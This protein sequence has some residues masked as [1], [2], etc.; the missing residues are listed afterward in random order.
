MFDGVTSQ[1]K[2]LVMCSYGRRQHIY[3]IRD[4]TPLES[5]PINTL[6]IKDLL[7]IIT[8]HTKNIIQWNVISGKEQKRISN[9]C[10]D[11][12]EL[13][14]CVLGDR[15]RKFILGDS[16]GNVA[17]YSC[18]TVQKLRI[19]PTLPFSV[20]FLLYSDDQNV[21][22]V[23][24]QADIF[25]LDATAT[26]DDDSK[27]KL[28]EVKAHDVDIICIAYSRMFG[29]IATADCL[30]TLIIWDYLYLSMEMVINNV[31]SDS[32]I[33]HMIFLEPY[34]LLLI[35]DCYGN[36]TI[37]AVPPASQ[38]L[39]RRIWRV[40]TSVPK[41]PLNM[42]LPPTANGAEYATGGRTSR[43]QMPIRPRSPGS[44]HM[45][46]VDLNP[47]VESVIEEDENEEDAEAKAHA[48]S[49][50]KKC[51]YL[52]ERRNVKQL[53]LH[54]EPIPVESEE[55]GMSA[56][57]TIDTHTVADTMV[58]NGRFSN[59]SSPLASVSQ[60]QSIATSPKNR[61]MIVDNNTN[62]NESNNA[63]TVDTN[64]SSDAIA[65]ILMPKSSHYVPAA[66]HVDDA[67]SITS[68][69]CLEE[70][71]RGSLDMESNVSIGQQSN[72]SEGIPVSTTDVSNQ[73]SKQVLKEKKLRSLDTSLDTWGEQHKSP[74]VLSSP[75]TGGG[76]GGGFTS[77]GMLSGL[78]STDEMS[79]GPYSKR[80]GKKRFNFDEPGLNFDVDSENEEENTG[81]K[82]SEKK[83]V[84][85]RPFTRDKRVL[86]YCGM[87]DGTVAVTDITHA[88]VKINL[89]PIEEEEYVYNQPNYN[90]KKRL[91]RTVAKDSDVTRAT[92]TEADIKI[93]EKYC[94]STLELVWNAHK[95]S[96][97][98]MEFVGDF[99]DLMTSTE[100]G[101][102]LTWSE[103]G[104]ARGV[105]T[106]GREWDN[107][108]P[109]R[110][111]TPIDIE[112]RSRLRLQEAGDF[113]N[114]L[115]LTASLDNESYLSKQY[116]KHPHLAPKEKTSRRRGVINTADSAKGKSIG[117]HRTGTPMT[118]LS[119]RK[120]RDTYDLG[121]LTNAHSAIPRLGSSKN[122]TLGSM[123]LAERE[124]IL[125][126][127]AG[128]VTY[129][130]SKKDLANSVLS[131]KHAAAMKAIAKI[132]REES[133]ETKKKK[134]A[135]K[136]ARRKQMRMIRQRRDSTVGD[137]DLK[138]NL[139]YD[140]PVS[141]QQKAELAEYHSDK[142][143]YE[144]VTLDT[145]ALL[146]SVKNDVHIVTGSK[147]T[148]SK[149]DIELSQIDAEDSNNWE[150]QSTNRQRALYA[151]L[152][153]ELDRDG[154]LTNNGA[155][156]SLTHKLDTLSGGN[157]TAY[158][159]E[160][161]TIRKKQTLKNT[162]RLMSSSSASV[163]PSEMSSMSMTASNFDTTS[164]AVIATMPLL[165][166]SAEVEY[167][168]GDSNN[169]TS[170]KPTQT[171]SNS[172]KPGLML[173][174][175]QVES[176]DETVTKSNS[177]NFTSN[178]RSNAKAISQLRTPTTA[179]STKSM[180]K[181]VLSTAPSTKIGSKGIPAMETKPKEGAKVAKLH[182]LSKETLDSHMLKQAKH[183]LRNV[184]NSNKSIS[185]LPKSQDSIVADNILGK[186]SSSG[187][188]TPGKVEFEVSNN[189]GGVKLPPILNKNKSCPI[190]PN[191]GSDSCNMILK[192]PIGAGSR[193]NN[194]NGAS[195]PTTSEPE[196]KPESPSMG[197]GILDAASRDVGNRLVLDRKATPDKIKDTMKML[198]ARKATE[199]FGILNSK[200]NAVDDDSEFEM[201]I[202]ENVSDDN[203]MGSSHS[204]RQLTPPQTVARNLRS[205][206]SA[207][208]GVSRLSFFG[209]S[210]H[211]NSVSNT[212]DPNNP[213]VN[214]QQKSVAEI[215][216]NVAEEFASDWS[217]SPSNAGS[218]KRTDFQSFPRK[219]NGN[220]MVQDCSK[221]NGSEYLENKK[222]EQVV[223]K[224]E[225]ALSAEK[226]ENRLME[227]ESNY[228]KTVRARRRGK[229]VK[230][231]SVL[232]GGIISKNTLSNKLQNKKN[233]TN[234]QGDS[235][236]LRKGEEVLA[237]VNAAQHGDNT[238]TGSMSLG[239]INHSL[240][241]E[242]VKTLKSELDKEE[243][244]R[245]K[246][247]NDLQLKSID[248]F[249]AVGNWSRKAHFYMKGEKAMH[250]AFNREKHIGVS[251]RASTIDD[252]GSHAHKIDNGSKKKRCT[253]KEILART[254][255]GP[256]DLPDL[257]R[258]WKMFSSIH[259]VTMASD[260]S[261]KY[262]QTE[263]DDGKSF[264]MTT[265]K[266]V[267]LLVDLVRHPFI[268]LRPQFKMDI[269]EYVMSHQRSGGL[270]EQLHCTMTD[271]L[272]ALCP[273]MLPEDRMDCL[274]YLTL[275]ESE[276]MKQREI[277]DAKL[278]EDN[279]NVAVDNSLKISDEDFD[280]LRELFHYFDKDGSGYI[281]QEEVMQAMFAQDATYEA[282]MI[283]NMKGDSEE[284]LHTIDEGMDLDAAAVA[285][286]MQEGDH[287]DNAIL[288][289]KEF[290]LLFKD[291]LHV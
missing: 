154:L 79:E 125:L 185:K 260:G 252:G 102:V 52:K 131:A 95:A 110:W 24:G 15:K 177:T 134:M 249:S 128:E 267:I 189:E 56:H 159:N 216:A 227:I 97:C 231:R 26:E 117:S 268:K 44:Y 11:S 35:P 37:I 17:V 36:F 275:H 126:Q 175:S 266:D 141:E 264:V 167:I 105:L 70:M 119:T 219:D 40:V 10:N 246:V 63:L 74:G 278:A 30:G 206:L 245:Q 210:K 16:S 214:S 280:T 283:R 191:N 183:G 82:T 65:A 284:A 96:C 23:G 137:D 109:P 53:C 72:M 138:F 112:Q 193:Y 224:T 85:Y 114:K 80:N 136:Q 190:F 122:H 86:V 290:C 21:I 200:S 18:L 271:I 157:F 198:I 149:Y 90:S 129:D 155:P 5:A 199:K 257:L 237:I 182:C 123:P 55:N 146:A 31:V 282:K 139:N 172:K 207:A 78:P 222:H 71:S 203:R 218:P 256:Y 244:E 170:L 27:Y 89:R 19:L 13:T 88:L 285:A 242:Q 166:E 152:Y 221:G 181:F 160:M 25:I 184:A 236:I 215:L 288:D 201:K 116:I 81:Q 34:P 7:L 118:P 174:L 261:L 107:I 274:R 130:L 178:L 98:S 48:F 281:E 9:L 43:A 91:Q 148:K 179:S 247:Y 42:F 99:D 165:K 50:K 205:S 59:P 62:F 209:A 255:F 135:N 226:F 144:S 29:L 234:F 239:L 217:K 276:L 186:G 269:E 33:G 2:G 151:H 14:A 238:H 1:Y 211:G 270:V 188:R 58:S 158:S 223:M 161:R 45:G 104:A 147:R 258:L 46:E 84:T 192:S 28:R 3:T 127:L 196:R 262:V 38:K 106:R 100:D 164:S 47:I 41:Y 176:T 180:K 197:S 265:V 263:S 202:P 241:E 168:E 150:I 113:V 187:A 39:G 251:V 145:D 153:N 22:A 243:M 171:H 77:P 68:D 194:V 101:S 103:A 60:S 220:G 279:K 253:D 69:A 289:F 32:E 49:Y 287:D 286:V 169:V 250:N 83:K 120:H 92:W 230:R 228:K 57:I 94:K 4:I 87:D 156:D 277:A 195:T 143:Y 133:D 132:G 54:Y 108:F 124:A 142:R 213:D 140:E 259:K 76:R 20:R 67:N 6:F 64:Q 232:T 162:Q 204:I 75:G 111:T 208:V 273:F 248:E 229:P 173:D 93:G 8:C 233:D 291:V 272:S 61:S 240:L 51:Q 73:P 163:L 212:N 225:N 66:I 121:S 12:S 115:K 235:H 254:N